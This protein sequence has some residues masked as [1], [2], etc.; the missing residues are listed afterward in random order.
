[1]ERLLYVKR[2]YDNPRTLPSRRGMANAAAV[3]NNDQLESRIDKLEKALLSA[4][5]KS[6]PQV[7]PVNATTV[8][9]QEDHYPNTT[10]LW[11]SNRNWNSEKQE[12]TPWREHLDFRWGERNSNQP[13]PPQNAYDGPPAQDSQP[14]W[15]GRNQ[16]NPHP[17]NPY[18]N[19]TYV[20][21]YQM[22][23]KNYQSHSP[24]H[25]QNHPCPNPNQHHH[26]NQFSQYP[27]HQNQPNYPYNQNHPIY[28]SHPN[29]QYNSHHQQNPYL[30]HL[31]PN[32]SQPHNSNQFGQYPSHQNQPNY[33][34]H[35]YPNTQYNPHHQQNPN[36]FLHQNKSG[37]S[38]EEMKGE[39]LVY[40]RINS[41]QGGGM[42][43][44]IACVMC[45]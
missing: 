27:S 11:N 38:V 13:N 30:H 16:H 17:P 21:Q 31:N 41:T 14:N 12:D 10:G 45:L 1:M 43:E 19:T 35:P 36:H 34:Y 20:P 3:G 40:S 7:P 2:A 32:H 28:Q 22:G 29:G 8:T 42:I 18:Q 23:N 26:P 15:S 44:N 9:A 39:M 4:I 37:R 5:E 25:C 33:T 24:Q 6:K